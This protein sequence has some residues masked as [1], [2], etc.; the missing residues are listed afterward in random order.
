MSRF[1][2]FKVFLARVTGYIDA[3]WY[4]CSVGVSFCL[5]IL[6]GF[7]AGQSD[8]LNRRDRL[9]VFQNPASYF[10]PTAKLV[11]SHTLSGLREDQTLVIVGGNSNFEAVGQEDHELWTLKLQ[12]TLGDKYKVVN[13]ATI[14]SESTDFAGVIFRIVEPIHPKTILVFN[15]YCNMGIQF[16]WDDR[17]PFRYFFWDAYY[18]GLIP[19]EPEMAEA[20]GRLKA[21]SLKY[22]KMKEIHLSLQLDA[23]LR[24]RDLWTYIGYKSFFTVW[25][26]FTKEAIFTPRYS[27]LLR[28]PPARKTLQDR[29]KTMD[30]THEDL[31]T[32][33]RSQ[34]DG[35]YVLAD[36][37]KFSSVPSVKETWLN[38]AR[39]NLPARQRAKTLIAMLWTNQYFVDQLNKNE[40]NAY[41]FVFDQ[42]ISDLRQIGYN[43]F[44]LGH[45]YDAE[46]FETSFH[47]VGSASQKM[48]D[49]VA[50]E[51]LKINLEN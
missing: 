4:L 15:S 31:M 9:N 34:F 27:P 14:G 32:N 50:R 28:E 16:Q 36:D 44:S 2:S 17:H 41:K 8:V 26:G 42:S 20:Y 30:M 24:A 13:L 45:D 10:F 6:M 21:E 12:T 39:N 7:L 33:L 1:N 38:N 46:D 11:L 22:E 3:K 23:V 40:Q 5:L 37:G 48:A 49:D 43:V 35:R 47:Y 25:S 19:L 18:K 29:L 51:V